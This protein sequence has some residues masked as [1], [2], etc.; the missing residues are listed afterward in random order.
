MTNARI[1]P[2]K[3][4][5]YVWISTVNTPKPTPNI[6]CPTYVRGVVAWSVAMK[7]AKKIELPTK[8]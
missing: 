8:R 1:E 7:N 2:P 6:P 5:M 3:K 4:L